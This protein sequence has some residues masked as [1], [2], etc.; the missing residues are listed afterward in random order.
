LLESSPDAVK[1]SIK[2]LNGKSFPRRY[3]RTAAVEELFRFAAAMEPEV[4]LQQRPFD[5]VTRF[6]A[7][8]LMENIGRSIEDCQLAG[9]QVF[10]RWAD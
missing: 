6:P 2:L 5:L 7:T 10:F 1:V 8:S 4:S 3:L 9:S